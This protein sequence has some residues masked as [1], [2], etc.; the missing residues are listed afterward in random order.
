MLGGVPVNMR[1]PL[2][3]PGM[4]F[5]LLSIKADTTAGFRLSRLRSRAMQPSKS[6]RRPNK[7]G[8]AEPASFSTP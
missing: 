1:E 8:Q 5:P 2:G 4:L 7:I 6:Q 3:I